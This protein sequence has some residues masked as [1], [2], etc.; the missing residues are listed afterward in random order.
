MIVIHNIHT[1]HESSKNITINAKKIAPISPTRKDNEPENSL[2][3]YFDDAFVF[4]GLI[5]SHDHLE[6]NL[7]PQLGNRVYK[8]YMEWGE[9]IHQQDKEIIRSVLRVPKELRVEWGIYKNLFAGITTVVH[10]GERLNI[11]NKTIN[12]FQD[13]YSL[14]SVNL[15]KLWK[16]KLNKPFARNQPYVIHVGEGTNDEAFKEINEL[17]RWS[18]LKRKLIGILA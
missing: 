5:N 9:D 11:N 6:F 15:E 17:I 1:I 10:H 3:L 4:P 2:H 16:L 12:I 7:F 8:S 13:C 18:F 14:H